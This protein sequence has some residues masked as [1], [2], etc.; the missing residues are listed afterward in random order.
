MGAAL[1]L[2]LLGLLSQDTFLRWRGQLAGAGRSGKLVLGMLLISIGLAVV[3]GFDKR[4]E[5]AIIDAFP[6]WLTEISTRY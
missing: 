2:I 1:P 5:A 4:L 3:S 6:T